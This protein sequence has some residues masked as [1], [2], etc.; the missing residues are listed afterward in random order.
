MLF[1]EC[2][3]HYFEIASYKIKKGLNEKVQMF[4]SNRI[5]IPEE[6]GFEKQN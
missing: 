5:N 1:P 2:T 3:K 4:E 6:L